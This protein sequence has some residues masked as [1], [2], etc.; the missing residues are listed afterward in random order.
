MK[1]QSFRKGT[2]DDVTKTFKSLVEG[3]Q[4]EEVRAIYR[5]GLNRLSDCYKKSEVDSVKWPSMDPE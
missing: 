1:E 3:Q 4:D 5:T 2:V